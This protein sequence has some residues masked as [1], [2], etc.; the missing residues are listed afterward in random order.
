MKIVP[1]FYSLE[2][3]RLFFLFGRFRGAEL[4]NW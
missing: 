3:D 4:L 2:I 1:L